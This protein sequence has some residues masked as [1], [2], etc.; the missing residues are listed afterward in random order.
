LRDKEM[1][2]L[3]T[4]ASERS[5]LRDDELMDRLW[6]EADGDAARNA[7]KVC[8]HRLRKDFGNPLVVRRTGKVYALLPGATVDLWELRDT[9]KACLK[10][11]EYERL[12][13]LQRL[14]SLLCDGSKD[15]ARLGAWFA[16]FERQLERATHE[17]EKILFSGSGAILH[18]VEPLRAPPE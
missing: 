9:S 2:L 3:F 15:R 18:S 10:Q 16:S 13:H 1:E 4:V 5:G 8:L 14:Y 12:D 11:R 6:P 7:F 17:S